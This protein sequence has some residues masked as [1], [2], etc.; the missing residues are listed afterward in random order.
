MNS[1]YQNGKI[2]C[3]WS[4]ETDEIYIGS[5]CDELNVRMYSHKAQFKQFLNGKIKNKKCCTSIHIMKYGDAQIGII[6]EYPCNTKQELLRREGELQQQIKCVN[7][8]VAGRTI[9]EWQKENKEKR[10]DYLAIYNVKNEEKIKNTHKKYYEKN[11]NKIKNIQKIYY[12]KNPK[13]I[14][15]IQKIYYEK[16]KE[17]IEKYRK[18][19]HDCE[20]GGFYLYSNKKRHLNAKKHIKWLEEKKILITD[21]IEDGEE[22]KE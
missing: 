13:K 11:K 20:C 9:K 19:N 5:T 7:R 6:E 10:K 2:Y 15:N 3:I 1:K 22:K 4:Y 21:N 18:E 12:E 16:N 17:T 14:R 8:L